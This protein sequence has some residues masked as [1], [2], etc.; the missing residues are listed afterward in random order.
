L[1]EY[2][3]NPQIM[4][5][6]DPSI[7]TNARCQYYIQ[8]LTPICQRAMRI[9]HE[10]SLYKETRPLFYPYETKL[11]EISMFNVNVI[12]KEIS[13]LAGEILSTLREKELEFNL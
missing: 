13:Q 10:I 2:E 11:V 4:L 6:F 1:L 5:M 8:T 12:N 7:F 9:L 3:N